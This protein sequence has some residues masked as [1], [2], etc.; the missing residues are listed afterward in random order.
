MGCGTAR[1][2]VSGWVCVKCGQ[3]NVT[4]DRFCTGCGAAHATDAGWTCAACGQANVASK[5]CTSCGTPRGQPAAPIPATSDGETEPVPISSAS[6]AG[7]VEK[8][9]GTVMRLDKPVIT[10]G[11]ADPSQGVL[12]DIAFAQQWVHRRYLRL[13]RRDD[14]WYLLQEPGVRHATILNGAKLRADEVRRLSDGDVVT[15]DNGDDAVH[16]T[17]RSR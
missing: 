15:L 5:F 12:P 11:R 6:I 9:D 16:F 2:Q 10:V 8:D 17:F 1:S 14:G 7:W 4:T 13:E 3:A